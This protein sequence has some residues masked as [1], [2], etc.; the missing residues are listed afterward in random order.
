M[1]SQIYCVSYE[2][3]T[4]TEKTKKKKRYEYIILRSAEKNIHLFL[5][6]FG[7]SLVISFSITRKLLMRYFYLAENIYISTLFANP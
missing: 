3:T 2:N 5:T 1:F 7:S 6:N 4:V